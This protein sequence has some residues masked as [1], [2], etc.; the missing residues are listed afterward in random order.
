MNV[1]CNLDARYT[2]IYEQ[3]PDN[4]SVWTWRASPIRRE[5]AA[6]AKRTVWNPKI[7]ITWE[8]GARLARYVQ[9]FAMRAISVARCQMQFDKVAVALL[10]GTDRS[11]SIFP[12][13]T[14]DESKEQ[15]AGD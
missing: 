11:R 10:L 14:F 8:V 5:R 15:L 4:E 13:S 1:S 6:G 9:F 2:R 3:E 7:L 12:S